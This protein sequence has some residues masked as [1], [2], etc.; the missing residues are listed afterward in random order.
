[1]HTSVTVK[2]INIAVKDT[3]ITLEEIRRKMETMM[4][5]VFEY[6]SS[7]DER[8][9]AALIDEKGGVEKV[10]DDDAV[11]CKL[12][13]QFMPDT[14]SGTSNPRETPQSK[15]SALRKE[16]AKDLEDIIKDD[17][18]AFDQKFDFVQA[19]LTELKQVFQGES[20]RII[21]EIRTGPHRRIVNQVSVAPQGSR[22]HNLRVD[23]RRIFI[24][25]GRI[26]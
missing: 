15:A 11:L 3:S 18:K 10:K 19:Q 21:A 12:V 14:S 23:V 26:W 9:I 7:A 13:D 1:M 20:D 22:R 25:C 2:D 4:E 17:S 8:R 16:I 5:T 24:I 6:M